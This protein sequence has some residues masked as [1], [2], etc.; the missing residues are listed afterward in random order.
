M[1]Q[2]TKKGRGRPQKTLDD[3]PKGWKAK[4][5][6]EMGEGA[7]QKEIMAE[8]KIGSQLFYDLVKRDKEFSN[9]IKKGIEMAEAWWMKQGRINLKAKRFNA[10]LWY[11]NMK[12]R[13]GWKDRAEVDH[14]G[15]L[16]VKYV[17]KQG[18]PSTR[19]H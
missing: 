18:N 12:N 14:K 8:L 17:I 3:L 4:V 7:S 1:L 9:T 10:V 16:F 15:Q 2:K 6:K 5:L 19:G 13:F 11:M